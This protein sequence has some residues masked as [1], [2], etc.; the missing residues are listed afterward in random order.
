M[1]VITLSKARANLSRYA[2]LCRKEPVIVT[3][4]GVPVFEMVPVE[5]DDDFID[6]LIENN[7][8]FR[9]YVKLCQDAPSISAKEAMR[10]LE[11]DESGR[12]YR[13]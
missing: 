8:K 13:K 4:K 9:E 5:E 3:V 12:S 1:K 2:R 6:R 10:R 11:A 7:P